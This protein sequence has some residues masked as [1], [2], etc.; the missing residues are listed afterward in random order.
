MRS[1]KGLVLACLVVAGLALPLAHPAVALASEARFGPLAAVAGQVQ[2]CPAGGRLGAWAIDGQQV[3]VTE[4]TAFVEE[5]G[6]ATVGAQVMVL[7]HVR[8]DGQLQALV[9][10]TLTQKQAQQ[11]QALVSRVQQATQTALR[12]REQVAARLRTQ[13]QAR[14]QQQLQARDQSGTQDQTRLQQQDRTQL[15][16]GSCTQDQT[17]LQQQEQMR[18]RAGQG[19]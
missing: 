15:R 7:A 14:T 2:S 5:A 6:P 10:R 9:V 3:Q 13:E 1:A 4:R 8:N 18:T 16:D 11:A 17:Q 19:R 12:L